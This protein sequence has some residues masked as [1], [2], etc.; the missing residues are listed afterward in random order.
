MFEDR[1][2]ENIQAEILAGMGDRVQTR[3]GSF[4]AEM[5]GPSAA[6]DEKIYSAIR[7]MV[8]LLYPDETCEGLID[9]AAAPYGLYRKEGTH[10]VASIQLSGRAGTTIPAGTVFLTDDGLE[11][12]LDEAVELN[13]NGVGEGSITAVDVGA[14]YNIAAGEITRMVMT[15]TGLD[16]WTNGAAT[17]GTDQEADKDLWSR[18]SDY[19][20][21]PRTS[22]NVYDYEAWAL[23]V[24]GVGAAKVFPVWAGPGTVKVLLIGPDRRPVDQS[25]VSAAAAHIEEQRAIGASVT[26]ESAQGTPINVTAR[27]YLDGSISL[28]AAKAQFV[29]KLDTYLQSVAFESYTVLINRIAFLLLGIEGIT[30]YEELKVNGGADNVTIPADNVP[31]VGTVELT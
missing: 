3:E 19:L 20:Q 30:D 4:V 24:D 6:E 10:A 9:L 17:G 12:A 16:A 15:M 18:Y 31:V 5:V 2:K 13:G 23:E 29:T 1:T 21:R 26:V 27:V 25:I 8:Y 7:A 14:K 28:A 11:F 22:G